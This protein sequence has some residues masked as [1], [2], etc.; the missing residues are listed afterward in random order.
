MESRLDDQGTV[1]LFYDKELNSFY[2]EDGFPIWNI[3][4]FIT[5]NDLF[6]FHHHKEYMLVPCTGIP[7]AYCELFYPEDDWKEF[8]L[9]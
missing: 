9:T 7:E 4:D 8:N 2:D 5:P 3:F 6:L 1:G